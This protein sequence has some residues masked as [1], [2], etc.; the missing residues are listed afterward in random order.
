MTAPYVL[1]ARALERGRRAIRRQ[2]AAAAVQRHDACRCGL[3]KQA[4]KV[5]CL[6]CWREAPLTVRNGIYSKDIATRRAA[7][8]EL[9][10]IAKKRAGNQ[11]NK[12]GRDLFGREEAR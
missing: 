2:N 7:A 4:N 6:G 12:H 10:E 11:E 9:L 3:N 5:V 8:R 1:H